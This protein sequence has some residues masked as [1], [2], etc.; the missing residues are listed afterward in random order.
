MKSRHS[1][2]IFLAFILT[3][4][5]PAYFTCLQKDSE[6][7]CVDQ[8][9]DEV[10]TDRLLPGVNTVML[11]GNRIKLLRK[12]AF[13]NVVYGGPWQT[14]ISLFNNRIEKIEEG[15]FEGM[16]TS[17]LW[18]LTLSKNRL[19]SI[20]GGMWR[21]LTY[22]QHMD[23]HGNLLTCISHESFGLDFD[24]FDLNLCCNRLIHVDRFHSSTCR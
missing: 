19:R 14:G 6:Y 15:A 16:N 10:P 2:C 18:L 3:K 22:V 23:L 13:R 20:N 11:L 4:I 5:G 17:R 7:N 24:T 9:L 8:N 1:N 12:G 21:G